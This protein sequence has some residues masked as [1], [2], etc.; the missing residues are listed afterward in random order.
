VFKRE[1]TAQPFLRKSL[2]R[3]VTAGPGR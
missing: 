2:K 1:R 3:E